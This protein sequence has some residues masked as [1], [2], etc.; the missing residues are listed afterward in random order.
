MWRFQWR[1]G[2]AILYSYRI[3]AFIGHNI[4]LAVHEMC[5]NVLIILYFDYHLVFKSGKDGKFIFFVE[6]VS[7]ISRSYEHTQRHFNIYIDSMQY[8]NHIIYT[9][10]H[11]VPFKVDIT[12]EGINVPFLIANNAGNF[13]TN[14]KWK[15]SKMTF[16]ILRLCSGWPLFKCRE[17]I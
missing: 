11:C 15:V 2:A 12:S 9:F 17:C 3:T 7:N 1:G 16:K 6:S 8:L 14:K 5:L 4:S 13:Q 10:L